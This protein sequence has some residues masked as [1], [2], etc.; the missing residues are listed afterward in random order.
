MAQ[1]GLNCQ[2]WGKILFK[3]FLNLKKSLWQVEDL[4]WIFHLHG[5]TH[6]CHTWY[7]PNKRVFRTKSTGLL[8]MKR[9]FIKLTTAQ[10]FGKNVNIDG[11]ISNSSVPVRV[12]TKNIC[13][14]Y[15][16][17]SRQYADFFQ[18]QFANRTRKKRSRFVVYCF[19]KIDY[20]INCYLENRRKIIHTNIGSKFRGNR[21]SALCPIWCF[22]IANRSSTFCAP[23]SGCCRF[24]SD[25]RRTQKL[26]FTGA[27]ALGKK[28]VL[29]KNIFFL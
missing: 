7:A 14:E 21:D 17:Y 10:I 2:L 11:S 25:R 9:A 6:L 5:R 26:W 4:G 8:K 18:L 23:V 22:W 24:K 29:K 19:E 27:D 20:W 12:K 28:Y 13:I 16:T 1:N 3:K 15:L